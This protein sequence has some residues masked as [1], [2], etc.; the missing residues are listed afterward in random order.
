MRYLPS[1]TITAKASYPSTPTSTRDER[2]MEG[3]DGKKKRWEEGGVV[4]EGGGGVG[5]EGG[6][7]AGVNESA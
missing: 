1:E 7:S 2:R 3:H 6:S 4:R 5:D